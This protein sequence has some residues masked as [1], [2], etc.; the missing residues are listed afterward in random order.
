[1]MVAG[2]HTLQE[3][4]TA[5]AERLAGLPVD[6]T[7]TAAVGN[8]YRAAGATRNHFERTVLAPHDLTWTGWVVLWVVWVWGEI[9]T[10]LVA[11]EAGISKGT[12]T[13][14][15]STLQDRRLVRRRKH[16]D[17]GRRVLLSLTPA[18]RR[19]MTTLF[20][21][22]NAQEV[23]VV[24]GLTAAETAALTSALRK[25]VLQLQREQGDGTTTPLVPSAATQRPRPRSR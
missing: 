3:T 17:D 16:P 24:Q 19:L 12:L 20:P 11:A 23:R 4:E 8:L 1:M 6:L 13:G 25:I 7:S 9:E 10:R 14:V 18:G 5:V 22:F 21:A 15:A 2:E